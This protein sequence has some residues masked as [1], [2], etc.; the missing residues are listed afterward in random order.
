MTDNTICG[1]DYEVVQPTILHAKDKRKAGNRIIVEGINHPKGEP[2][3]FKSQERARHHI[4]N[5][6]LER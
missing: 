3:R 2:I 6:R 1:R 4:Q 5:M